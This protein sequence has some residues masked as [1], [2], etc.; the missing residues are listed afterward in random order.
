[1]KVNVIRVLLTKCEL[2]PERSE[3]NAPVWKALKRCRRRVAEKER[4][5]NCGCHQRPKHR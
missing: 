2:L 1:M 3:H 5:H 4:G